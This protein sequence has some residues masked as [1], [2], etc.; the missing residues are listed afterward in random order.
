MGAALA[1][2]AAAPRSGA[3]EGAGISG[4]KKPPAIRNSTAG[5]SGRSLL[6][7]DDLRAAIAWRIEGIPRA[8]IEAIA[9]ALR[10]LADDFR[11]DR[12]AIAALLADLRRPGDRRDA[13]G[14][15]CAVLADDAARRG[16]LSGFWSAGFVVA[17]AA[18]Q[19]RR[20]PKDRSPLTEPMRRFKQENPN[21]FPDDAFNAFRDGACDLVTGYL[22]K[23]DALQVAGWSNVT[24]ETFSR[25]YQRL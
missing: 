1:I 19:G 21:H 18:R 10:P 25:Q 4:P 23:D 20:M 15:A 22:S 9:A 3:R 16:D 13:W 2:A 24:R 7:A 6:T 5:V 8:E 14:L 11:E 12:P 17:E